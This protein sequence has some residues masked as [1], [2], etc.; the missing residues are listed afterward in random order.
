MDLFLLTLLS[1]A[2]AAGVLDI[3]ALRKSS[4]SLRLSASPILR[5]LD[6]VNFL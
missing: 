3:A 2:N 4:Y 1:N 6:P 5:E